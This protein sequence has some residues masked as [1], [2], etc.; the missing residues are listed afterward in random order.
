M[1]EKLSIIIARSA[2]LSGAE[3]DWFIARESAK[4]SPAN[5][6]LSD[7]AVKNEFTIW[8]FQHNHNNRSIM[9]AW[10]PNFVRHIFN[11]GD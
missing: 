7:D 6:N 1:E 5:Q 11:K 9:P 8:S 10:L 3:R 4:L 2:E